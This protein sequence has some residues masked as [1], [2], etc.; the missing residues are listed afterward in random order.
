MRIPLP[1]MMR[2]WREREFEKHL[3]PFTFRKGLGI[4]AWF[5]KR[6]KL[7]QRVTRLAAKM[8]NRM[9]KGKGRLSSVPLAGG[10]VKYRDMPAPQGKTFQDMWKERNNG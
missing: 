7:Y 5:A 2:N 9:A 8:L 4:W 6:P 3:S 1:R 10:W